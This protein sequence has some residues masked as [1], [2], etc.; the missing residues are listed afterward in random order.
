MALLITISLISVLAIITLQFAKS[1]R[2]EYVVTASL[3]N[4]AQLSEM[5]KSGITIA[6][7][8]L[9]LDLKENNF[10]SLYDSWALLGDEEFTDLFPQGSLTVKVEDEIGKYQLNAMVIR[11]REGYKPQKTKKEE[12][13]VIQQEMDVR[14]ILWRLLRAE[15]FFVE[16][17][18]A[19][20]IIDSLIDWI[21]T[22]D[23]D[24]E[25]EYGAED[26]YYQSL[27]PPY[28]C[29][30]GPVESIDELLLVK[31]FTREILYGTE[32][33]PPLAPLLSTVISD[34]SININSAD[35]LLLQALA[36]GLS[37]TISENMVDYRE[38]EANKAL[39]ED[40]SWY[41]NVSAFP[42]DIELSEKQ[43]RIRSSFFS[44]EATAS[45]DTQQKMIRSTVE[46]T[47]QQI[48]TLR[49]DS[50]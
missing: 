4:S 32:D 21:D 36:P 16:D 29:K 35:I 11:K 7:Q 9:I 30:N 31:G 6:R 5:A 42:G 43:I 14:N 50:E 40:A 26:S 33:K 45:F 20:E 39:L 19:R 12:E 23:G 10:D 25:E 24:G 38:N 3:K 15:P 2:Q 18:T 27:T 17:G 41:K 1:M 34:G 13:E 28:S 46:R 8:L 22:G 47:D 44:I 37:K 49:W 48:K